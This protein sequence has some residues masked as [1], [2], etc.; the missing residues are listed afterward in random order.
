MARLEIRTANALSTLVVPDTRSTCAIA[1]VLQRYTLRKH[2][3]LIIGAAM[4]A[5][6]CSMIY[7]PTNVNSRSKYTMR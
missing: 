6:R 3:C 7:A 2:S 1:I 5:D 4:A